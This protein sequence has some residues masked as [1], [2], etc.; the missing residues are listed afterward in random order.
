MNNVLDFLKKNYKSIIKVG[1]L[2]FVLYWLVFVLTPSVKM[3]ELSVY[4]IQE[5]QQQITDFEQNQK[6]M[7]SL[8]GNYTKEIGQIES[9]LKRIKTQ[10]TIIKE[11]YHEEI[12]RVDNYDS[13][14]LDSFFARR[15][16]FYSR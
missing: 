12:N 1:L 14:Q 16:G 4:K 10:K 7:D 9:E 3:S 2:L 15:Y 13:R 8:I 11:I 6:K 5:L